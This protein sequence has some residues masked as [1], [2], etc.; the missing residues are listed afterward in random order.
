MS[1]RD[2]KKKETLEIEERPVSKGHYNFHNGKC[3]FDSRPKRQR[4]RNSQELKWKRE[5]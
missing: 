2:S 3:R 5:A 4:T 1:K